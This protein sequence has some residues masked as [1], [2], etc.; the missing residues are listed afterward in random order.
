[1]VSLEDFK[2]GC[3]GI[4]DVLLVDVIKGQPGSDR[5]LGEGR[6]GNYNGLRSVE[7][8]LMLQLAPL[9]RLF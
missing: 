5:D 7:R 3:G 6:G 8:H 4:G 2:N 9:K 1:M